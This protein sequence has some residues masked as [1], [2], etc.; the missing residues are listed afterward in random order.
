MDEKNILRIVIENASEHPLHSHQDI[1]LIYV[2][3]GTVRVVVSG[4]E[5]P[6]ARDGILLVNS[7]IFHAWKKPDNC[8][9][10][11]MYINYASICKAV[12]M[13]HVN[14]WC[15][16]ASGKEHDMDRLRS[17]MDEMIREF[18]ACGLS[19]SFALQSCKYR[20]MDQ[21]IK[22]HL[23]PGYEQWKDVE[24]DRIRKVLERVNIGYSDPVQLSDIAGEMY[25]SESYLSRLFKN[26]VGM[27]FKDYLNHARLE[28]GLENIL[29]TSKSIAE[30]SEECGFS[31]PSAFNK[32]F[33]RTYG[34]SPT[35][36]KKRITGQDTDRSDTGGIRNDA[37][38]ELEAWLA[39]REKT[40]ERSKEKTI[41]I[42][43]DT[44]RPYEHAYFQCMNG[45]TFFDLIH[46]T[47]REQIQELHE[48]AGIRYLRL[49][50]IFNSALH[51]MERTGS[52]RF[53]FSLLDNS[54]DFL[55]SNGIQPIID[56][57]D[58]KKK[59]YSDIGEL[60]FSDEPADWQPFEDLDDWRM[61]LDKTFRHFVDRYGLERISGWIFEIGEDSDY[62]ESCVARGK[63]EIPYRQLWDASC[64]ILREICPACRIAG[65]DSLLQFRDLEVIPDYILIRL[66]PY[67][68]RKGT[69]EDSPER[70]TSREFPEQELRKERRLL[71]ELGYPD[72]KLLVSEWDTS[73]SER[74]YYNDTSGKAAHILRHL[75]ALE[76]Q[77][78]LL[79]Y[80]HGFD[81]LSQYLDTDAPF[82]GGSGLISKD[83]IKKPLF[84]AFYFMNQIHGR[85]LAKADNY[86]VVQSAEA[87]YYI[88]TFH[89]TAFHHRYFMHPESETKLSEVDEIFE[90]DA[91]QSL[92]FTFRNVRDGS[93]RVKSWSLGRENGSALYEWERMGYPGRMNA[94]EIEYL[95][96]VCRP[97][98][99]GH[100]V[101]SRGGQLSIEVKL[102][103]HQISLFHIVRL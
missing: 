63:E 99:R 53:N 55:I 95:N 82:V 62:H 69:P 7:G 90:D 15:S 66:Y 27:S 47:M 80:Q 25:I 100:E 73:F 74:N 51:L 13:Y 20:L 2:L 12:G 60:L 50:G 24:D 88:L 39:K 21:L 41:N 101:A 42:F 93:Y 31:D 30:I 3:S 87:H 43:P 54:M 44:G 17:V 36:Y 61:L 49:Q 86:L 57:P 58:W 83:G 77:H 71:E 5:Y 78:V 102:E 92:V 65:S 26:S 46:A 76:D 10:C 23:L 94:A 103:P 37:S 22:E 9:V 11:K 56:L 81:F 19:D 45:G 28:Y 35:E 52:S 64:R 33:R 68:M 38:E 70:F 14:F 72:M 8:L 89:D 59:A 75:I 4:R 1:E 16:S 18:K 6:L 97:R 85:V 40:A 34:C 91:G 48:K 98:I 96:G 32:L 67:R 84:Y 29:Y 79:C